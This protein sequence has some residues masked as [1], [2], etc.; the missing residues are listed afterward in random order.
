MRRLR[1]DSM[2]ASVDL[3]ALL[4]GML[5]IVLLMKRDTSRPMTV[6][7]VAA[8]V[9]SV[10]M[11]VDS[12]IELQSIVLIGTLLVILAVMAVG[13]GLHLRGNVRRRTA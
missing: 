2:V 11:V 8:L 13:V 1:I 12:V 4:I 5:M 3:S 10:I 6:A 9:G 7:L